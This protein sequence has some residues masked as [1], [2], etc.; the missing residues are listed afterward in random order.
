[1]LSAGTSCRGDR[2]CVISGTKGFLTVDNV[3]NPTHIELFR[4]EDGFA[5]PEVIPLPEQITGYEYEVRACLRAI[6]AGATE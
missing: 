6:E 5:Q 4:A 3:N 1:M 2:R